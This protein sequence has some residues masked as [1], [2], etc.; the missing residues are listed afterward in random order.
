MKKYTQAQLRQLVRLGVAEDYTN[1]PGEYMDTLR[2]LD[3]IGYS[4]GIY[5]INGGLLRHPRRSRAELNAGIFAKN[6][7]SGKMP[8]NAAGCGN[9][10]RLYPCAEN[11]Y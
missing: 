8:G 6:R 3:K 4:A 7:R 10:G 5:G 9:F 11:A 1:K 2:R